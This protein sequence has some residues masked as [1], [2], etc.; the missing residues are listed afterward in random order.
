M[1]LRPS[2]Y[3]HRTPAEGLAPGPLRD[4]GH[5]F[6]LPF[7]TVEFPAVDGSTLRGWLV[8]GRSD[9]Q[10]AVVAVHGGGGDRR[11]YLRLA[12]ALHAAGYPTLLFDCREHGISDGTGRGL[13]FG[14]REQ[15]DVRAAV[16]WLVGERG[17]AGVAGLGR[18]QGAV[19]LLQAAQSEPAIEA[20]VW[21]SGGVDL[22]D[23]IATAPPMREFSP[24]FHRLVARVL[25]WR[26]GASLRAVMTLD[27]STRAAALQLASRP[28]LVIHGDRD[29]RVPVA[30][31]RAL[32]AAA[33]EPR[34]LW[35]VEG[36][37]HR[38]IWQVAGEAYAERIVRFLERWAPVSGAA[39]A[40]R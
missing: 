18:S 20:L 25:L 24:W 33:S 17:F 9:A 29:E 36:A 40:P 2:F 3:E 7:E 4:P 19:S 37:G 1:G 26:A 14:V 34:S 6:G 5:D 13:S 39:P 15:H 28:L 30:Q 12:P 16:S 27:T 38:D 35:I 11:S 10:R 31:G 32:Y 22:V 21:E 23:V 8:P